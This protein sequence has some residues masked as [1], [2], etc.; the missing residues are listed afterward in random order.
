MRILKADLDISSKTNEVLLPQDAT[1][2]HI[3]EQ[4]SAF[5]QGLK[6]W[7]ATESKDGD[8]DVVKHQISY[9]M[10]GE[11]FDPKPGWIILR[12]IELNNGIYLHIFDTS[13]ELAQV[14]PDLAED[15]E[16]KTITEDQPT[17]DNDGRETEKSQEE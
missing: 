1:I 14:S 10:T 3:A 12:S 9:F 7:F 8:I 6:L 4:D 16:D 2:I 17:G 13:V 5:G 11:E 15:L